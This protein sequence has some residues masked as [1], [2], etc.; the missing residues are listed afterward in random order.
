MLKIGDFSNLGR[1]TVKTLRLYDELGL[2][3]PV[4]VDKWTGYRYYAAS[5]LERLH[6]ILALK[7]LGFSLEQIGEMLGDKLSAEQ[8]KGMLK[9]KRA[10]LERQ[11]DEDKMRLARIEARLKQFE[12][13]SNMNT[14]A[15]VIKKLEPTTVA[16]IRETIPTY[17]DV[18]RLHGEMD[19]FFKS[20]GLREASACMSI[21]HDDEYKDREVDAEGSLPHHARR[22]R[23]QWPRAGAR[24]AWCR[25]GRL[26]RPSRALRRAKCRI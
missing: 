23:K 3:K 21:W 13:E 11:L 20:R 6:R 1:V 22:F 19:A 17:Q 18:G 5:Q 9:L 15:V 8:I 10:E 24:A 4:E 25:A 7:E 26:P 16:F 12:K 14:N 2:L